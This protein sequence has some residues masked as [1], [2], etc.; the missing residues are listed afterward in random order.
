MN[1]SFTFLRL[2][3]LFV[4]E[5]A[6]SITLLVGLYTAR[7]YKVGRGSTVGIATRYGLDVPGI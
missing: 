4:L 1:I 7:L 6:F 2:S 3:M 5:F